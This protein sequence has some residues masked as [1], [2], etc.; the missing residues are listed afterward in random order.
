M[1]SIAPLWMVMILPFLGILAM[2][3][4]LPVLSAELSLT[5]VETSLLALGMGFASVLLV[6]PAFILK[7]PLSWIAASALDRHLSRL[8]VDVLIRS[9][10]SK[11]IRQ[12]FWFDAF[13]RT[14]ATP[15][16][17]I[18]ILGKPRSES[19]FWV[20]DVGSDFKKIVLER[21]SP[22]EQ[23][24]IPL[25]KTDNPMDGYQYIHEWM[26]KGGNRR[27]WLGNL[28]LKNAQQA[29]IHRNKFLK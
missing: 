18:V 17:R 13:T 24:T 15:D 8:G 19:S 28:I 1:S 20:M 3:L 29:V 11:R 21:Y 7:L 4:V 5:H 22:G 16:R 12:K 26:G 23:P 6:L 27:R 2:C 14:V 25:T 10:V 9:Q